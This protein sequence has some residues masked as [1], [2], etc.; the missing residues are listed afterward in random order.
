MDEAV[1]VVRRIA[2][3][4][5][6]GI[7][8][9]LGLLAALDWQLQEFEKQS[10]LE[11]RLDILAGDVQVNPAVSTAVFRIVKESLT[12]ILRH[13]EARAVTLT[14]AQSGPSLHVTV[15]DDGRGLAAG[16]LAR[17]QSLGLMGMRERAKLVSG[18]LEISSEP[19]Q[20][21]TVRVTVPLETA[22][23]E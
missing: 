2:S 18:D 6:P 7:L 15:H 19:G 22:E 12:N 5:R 1:D 17:R 4:L 11:C 20:G 16:Q 8:D 13:A 14:V 10:G 23:G 21:T 3:D 9:D